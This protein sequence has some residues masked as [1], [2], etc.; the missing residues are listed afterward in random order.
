ML[1]HG[2]AYGKEGTQL[3]GK[4]FF[5][6]VTTGAAYQ[7]YQKDGMHGHDMDDFLLPVMRTAHFCH[8]RTLPYFGVHG[9]LGCYQRRDEAPY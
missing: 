6:I 7:A 8:M 3:Q 9:T 1:Q 4:L 5:P 2:W